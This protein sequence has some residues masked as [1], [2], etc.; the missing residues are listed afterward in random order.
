V[1]EP[2]TAERAEELGRANYMLLTTYRK[3]GTPVSTPLWCAVEDGVLYGSTQAETGKVKRM[4]RDGTATVA[5]C[6][7]RGKATGPA[8]A[9]HAEVLTGDAGHHAHALVE[10]RFRL[11][12][13]LYLFSRL[14]LR[15]WPG[16]HYDV[17]GVAVRPPLPSR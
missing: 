6:T 16:R 4:R 13:P 11:A 3:D 10:K 1:T 2:L 5:P 9:A 8:Y 7:N 15:L 12:K 14:G 17:V